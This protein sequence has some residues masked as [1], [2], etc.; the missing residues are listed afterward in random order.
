MKR[1]I[2]PLHQFSRGHPISCNDRETRL[3]AHRQGSSEPN[4]SFVKRLGALA[5][6]NSI[7][8]NVHGVKSIASQSRRSLMGRFRRM[9][10]WMLLVWV[11][12]WSAA[13]LV[14]IV[15]IL[16]SAAAGSQSSGATFHQYQGDTESPGSRPGVDLADADTVALTD[17]K[18][19]HSTPVQPDL[20]VARFAVH[21]SAPVALAGA[22]ER[23]SVPPP[24]FLLVFQRL[25]L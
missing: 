11:L 2:S 20:C 17:V 1:I 24:D 3:L 9:A 10:P 23:W 19:S 18:S 12:Y 15:G 6:Q 25:L 22:S 16:A 14:P 4:L 13:A 21:A 8:M 7:I 5:A